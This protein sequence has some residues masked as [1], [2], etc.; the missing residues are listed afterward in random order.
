[1]RARA[2][3]RS[4]RRASSAVALWLIFLGSCRASEDGA[5]R[6]ATP[7]PAAGFQDAF[8]SL[9]LERWTPVRSHDAKREVLETRE[10]RLVLGLDTL[11]T[12]D[13]TVKAVGVR[14]ARPI[15]VAAGARIT[16]T[17]DW[18][19]QENTSYLAAGIFLSPE[20]RENA[21][22][23]EDWI[24]VQLVGVPP[25][26]TA[27]PLVT[28]RSRGRMIELAAFGWPIEKPSRPLGR[29]TIGIEIRGTSLRVDFGGKEVFAT[30]E[31]P[32]LLE[33]AWLYLHFHGHSNYP[34]REIAF[35]DITVA[36]LR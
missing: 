16:A 1:M 6:D 8:D 18:G 2:A 32:V 22:E 27:R 15:D 13:A 28:A 29:E 23:A 5:P 25:G 21:R 9:S 30:A 31:S 11:G 24:A 20:A 7:P 33:R 36:Q 4:H 19:A 34:L 12:D 3:D 10:G 35:D 14:T 17:F 26:Q